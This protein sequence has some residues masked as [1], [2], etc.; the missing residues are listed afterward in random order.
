MNADMGTRSALVQSVARLEAFHSSFFPCGLFMVLSVS[1]LHSN[2]WC[3]DCEIIWK[4][5]A[6]A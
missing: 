2:Q 5:V 1:G 4:E 6:V 3:D